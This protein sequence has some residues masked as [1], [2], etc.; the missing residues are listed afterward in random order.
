MPLAARPRGFRVTLDWTFHFTPFFYLNETLTLL[1]LELCGPTFSSF[2]IGKKISYFE[3]LI[4]FE[5][6]A[7][8]ARQG[9]ENDDDD[10]D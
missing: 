6:R 3:S 4:S 1:L 5:K 2:R 7:N 8:E 9:G 10:D